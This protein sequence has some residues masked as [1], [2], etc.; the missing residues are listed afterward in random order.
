M[1]L[2]RWLILIVIALLAAPGTAQT[3]EPAG[4]KDS[5]LDDISTRLEARLKALPDR[6]DQIPSPLVPVS[7]RSSEKVLAAAS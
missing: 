5:C 7:G 6:W 4:S 1:K 3:N 2:R